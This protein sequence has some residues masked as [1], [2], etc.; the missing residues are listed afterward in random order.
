MHRTAQCC[1]ILQV[2]SIRYSAAMRTLPLFRAM[3]AAPLLATLMLPSPAHAWGREGHRLVAEVAQ[4]HLAPVARKNVKA[5]LGSET[6]ADVAAWADEYRPLET[7]TGSWHYTDLPAGSD[8]YDRDRDCPAQ[9]GVKLGSRND[10]WRDC[11]TER[12]LFFEERLRDTNLDPADRAVA[13]KY[14]VHFVGDIH[15]PM[16]AT[17]VEKGGNTIPV[18]AFGSTTC[19]QYNCNLHSVWD[20]GLLLHTGLSEPEYLRRL[21]KGIKAQHLIAGTNDPVAWTNESKQASDEAMLPKG[22]AVDEKYYSREIPVVDQRLELAGLRLAA[23][24]NG[25]F[26]APPRKFEPRHTAPSD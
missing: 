11:A 7:Q 3:T 6:L 2:S 21:E 1:I 26:T 18:S 4:D 22:A 14:L 5:L 9:P 12:I 20:S 24:L 16:H 17:G 13:L 23:V 8:V 10:K 25:I 19:G 15:Q